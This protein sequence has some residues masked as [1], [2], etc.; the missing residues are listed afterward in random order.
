[1]SDEQRTSLRG[2]LGRRVLGVSACMVVLMLGAAA[3]GTAASTRVSVRVTL[4]PTPT[5]KP[6]PEV[7][8]C[9]TVGVIPPSRPDPRDA[10]GNL[11]YDLTEA[12]PCQFTS[13]AGEPVPIPNPLPKDMRDMPGP[14]PNLTVTLSPLTA[15]GRATVEA[16][17][18]KYPQFKVT[19]IQGVQPLF[20]ANAQRDAIDGGP[21][22]QGGPLTPQQKR[23]GLY[24]MGSESDGRVTIHIFGAS[25]AA[26]AASLTALI[27]SAAHSPAVAA[28]D[29]G[30]EADV[31]VKIT[32]N[33]YSG[34][35]VFPSIRTTLTFEGGTPVCQ[36][37]KPVAAS[38]G[39]WEAG[40]APRG[41]AET[42]GGVHGVL[43]VLSPHDALFTADRGGTL[44]FTY[45][46]SGWSSLDCAI[47]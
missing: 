8:S 46:P 22:V 15:K 31:T 19:V 29:N 27:Q 38:V 2:L 26:T 5:T 32:L 37:P 24:D 36:N 30:A 42:P 45:N 3:C 13:L 14:S 47:N 16:I 10:T 28:L 35:T 11:Q 7:A 23:L 43:K 20:I 39:T 25:D 40:A 18:A 9:P 4:P 6:M 33:P 17:A 34:L 1:M 44:A 41:W 12:L 21:M